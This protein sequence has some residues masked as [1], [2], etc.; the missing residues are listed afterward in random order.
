MYHFFFVTNTPTDR[1]QIMVGGGEG[2]GGRL[3][4]ITQNGMRER[5]IFVKQIHVMSGSNTMS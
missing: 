1:N 5:W 4:G 3:H 2:G